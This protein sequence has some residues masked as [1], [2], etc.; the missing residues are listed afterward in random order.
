MRKIADI[1]HGKWDLLKCAMVHRIGEVPIGESSV[2]IIYSSAH[3]NDSLQAVSY[4]IDQLKATVSISMYIHI[5]IEIYVV[6]FNV[7]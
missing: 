3:R 6:A 5:S 1:A 4:S 2:V 7:I